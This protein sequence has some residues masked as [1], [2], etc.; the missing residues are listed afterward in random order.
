M[1]V[2]DTTYWCKVFDLPSDQS[3]HVI[4][5]DPIIDSDVLHHIDVYACSEDGMC[6][7]NTFGVFT[8]NKI[9][10]IGIV[11]N[12]LAYI[13][14]FRLYLQHMMLVNMKLDI[15][16]CNRIIFQGSSLHWSSFFLMACFKQSWQYCHYC[17]VQSL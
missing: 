13:Y 17:I 16:R 5:A 2:K 14:S 4:A 7:T 1:P 11:S 3:Y 15:S 10:N 6:L 9:G 12:V 8:T